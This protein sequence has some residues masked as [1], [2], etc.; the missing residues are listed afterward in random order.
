MTVTRR[1]AGIAAG[2]AMATVAG[3]ASAVDLT[4]GSWPPP[5]EY[6]NRVALPKIFAEIAKETNGGINWKLVPGGQL[7]GDRAT[8]QAASDGVIHAGLGIATYV[9]NLIPS[10]NAIY[11]TVVFGDDVVAA[12]GAAVETVTLNCPS[13]T[14]EAKKANLVLLSGWTSSAYRLACREPVRTLADLKGKRVRATGGSTELM[15]MAGATPVSATLPEAVQLLQRGG[16]DCQFGVHTWLKIFGYAD[17]AKNLTDY[18]LG[19]TGPAIGMLMNR[20]TW[21]KF[22]PDQKRIHMRQAA[23]LSAELALGQ[24]VIENEAILNEIKQTKNVQ[25]LSVSNPAEWSAVTEKYDVAQREKNIANA[26]NFGVA[27]PAAVLDAYA[28]AREKWAKMSPGIGRDIDK[29]SEALWNEVYSKAD[30]SKL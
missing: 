3:A 29:F 10:L 28:K 23:R 4:Y 11:S 9:P 26:R 16:L 6:L 25:V 13:C 30:P 24:F 5:G 22:T 15:N 20:D 7:A 19:I 18:P 21:N 12:S 17:F 1:I 27:N 2:L 8:F 14:E